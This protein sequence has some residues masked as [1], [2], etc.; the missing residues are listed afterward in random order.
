MDKMKIGLIGCGK[1]APKH[2]QGLKSLPGIEI[3]LSDIN[4]DIACRLAEKEDLKWVSDQEEFF[5]DGQF[6][7]IDVCT[8][9]NTHF[10]LIYKAIE[11]GMDVFC[12]KPLC[13]TIVQAH[14]LKKLLEK[15]GNFI[16]VGYIY[17]FVPILEEA[18]K[19]LYEKKIGSESMVLG[20]PLWALFRLGGRGSH[21]AWKHQKKTGGGAINEMLVHMVDLANWYFG[22]IKEIDPISIKLHR[23]ERK[24]RQENVRCDAEDFVLLQC[25]SY[26]DVDIYIQSDLT[27]PAF[28]QYI[29][30]QAENG[31][32]MGSIQQEMPSYV[33]LN[34]PRGGYEAGK[35]IFD[36]GR[37]N[38][39]DAQMMDFVHAVKTRKPPERNTIDDTIQLMELLEKLSTEMEK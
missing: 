31:S 27:T 34:E 39:F 25:A 19:L 29:E 1:Q 23:A 13:E 9:L 15:N 30:I 14:E 36:F 38:L 8:P 2:I 6:N 7:A 21:Q 5:S 32:F 16:Q 3:V 12:E 37:R 33:F 22:P 10:S 24:I 11:H 17:R 35:N 4:P 18:Y 26:E 28:S 20:K